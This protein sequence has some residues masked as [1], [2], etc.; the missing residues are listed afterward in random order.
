MALINDKL[1]NEEFAENFNPARFALIKYICE[2]ANSSEHIENTYLVEKA[3]SSI[4]QYQADL[5]QAKERVGLLV[6]NIE[7]R[8]PDYKERARQLFSQYKF[9]QLERLSDK[10]NKKAASAQTLQAL[11]QLNNEMRD[12][13]ESEPQV[14]LTQTLDQILFVQEQK[15]RFLAG[16][17]EL[18]SSEPSS[19]GFELQ[20]LKTV[21]ESMK[22]FNIDKTIDHAIEHFPENAGP[23]NP[24]M[25]AITSL[26]NMR[27]LSPQ[28]VRRFASY[29]GTVLW[30]EKNEVK[31]SRKK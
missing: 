6:S 5:D 20:S 4:E 10:L 22:Y 2:C 31:L 26:M 18:S 27:D 8:F 16:A 29:I 24:H 3:Q 14:D 30:L 1:I 21:R 12:N 11:A 15:A 9:K 28:Y 23:H 25:L 7:N 13:S 17:P 19:D